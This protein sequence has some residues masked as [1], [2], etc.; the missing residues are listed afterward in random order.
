MLGRIGNAPSCYDS[1]AVSAHPEAQHKRNEL[2]DLKK[3]MEYLY[4][5]KEKLLKLHPIVVDVIEK[6]LQSN[7]Y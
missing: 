2:D 1:V 3:G 7:R 5:F 6:L 4:E